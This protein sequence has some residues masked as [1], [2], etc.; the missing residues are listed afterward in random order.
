[1]LLFISWKL[2]SNYINLSESPRGAALETTQSADLGTPGVFLRQGNA[3]AE[4]KPT[5]RCWKDL[6]VARGVVTRVGKEVVTL[7]PR[8]S[9]VVCKAV[10][11]GRVSSL[12]QLR[13]TSLSATMVGTCLEFKPVFLQ[14]SYRDSPWAVWYFHPHRT[15]KEGDFSCNGCPTPLSVNTCTRCAQKICSVRWPICRNQLKVHT[16]ARGAEA[17][18]FGTTFLWQTP[19]RMR[20][21][22]PWSL[23]KAGLG[24][25]PRPPTLQQPQVRSFIRYR[26]IYFLPLT[27]AQHLCSTEQLMIFIR[28]DDNCVCKHVSLFH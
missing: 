28:T 7:Q 27:K 23:T 26:H 14:C 24:F 3:G 4:E 6:D 1:M 11:A 9:V 10:H 19:A 17:S 16:V 13:R 25:S 8:H 18:G 22:G 12:D 21:L 2:L 15:G 5:R 20:H